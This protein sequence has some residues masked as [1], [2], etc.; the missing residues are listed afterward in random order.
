[1]NKAAVLSAVEKPPVPEI[2]P[3]K[4]PA[5]MKAETRWI[6][7]RWVRKDEHWTKKP[8]GRWRD[9]KHH[10]T[11]NEAYDSYLSD[12]ADGVGFILGDGWSGVDLDNAI[13]DGKRTPLAVE[14]IASL[15]SYTEESP[16][17][18]G[19]KIYLK[20]EKPSGYRSKNADGTVEIYG[21][22]RWFVVTSD[23]NGDIEYRQTELQ[24]VLDKHLPRPSITVTKGSGTS[25]DDCLLEMLTIVPGQ[26]ESDGSNRLFQLACRIVEHNLSNDD[27]IAT[28]REYE[29]KHPFPKNW[30]DADITKRIEDAEGHAVR[31]SA[32]PVISLD[33]PFEHSIEQ[34]ESVLSGHLY[35]RGSKLVRVDREPDQAPHAQFDNQ[36]P[37]IATVA[38]GAFVE[39]VA[40]AAKYMKYDG[41]TKKQK[42]TLPD[43]RTLSCLFNR[44]EYPIGLFN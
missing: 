38:K 34:I 17:G 4:I 9:P 15:D 14:I 36:A 20:A 1:M 30:T 8:V 21:D 31:G 16:T 11:F 12:N 28:V 42:I 40:R 32:K 18:T 43:D 10:R 3:D 7:W 25:R 27:G 41:R 26:G 22:G 23:G 29:R 35:Q 6:T 13:V 33:V 5:A 2:N 19:L 37:R 39:Y 24:G 44:G